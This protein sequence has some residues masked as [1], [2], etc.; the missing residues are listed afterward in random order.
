MPRI[1]DRQVHCPSLCALLEG[2]EK[3]G[4]DSGRAGGGRWETRHSPPVRRGTHGGQ[5][6]DEPPSR[7]PAGPRPAR[8][9]RLSAPRPASP[10]PERRP[11]AARHFCGPPLAFLNRR[12]VLCRRRQP[13]EAPRH[14]GWRRRHAAGRPPNT[15]GRPRSPGWPAAAAAGGG[16]SG[17]GVKEGRQRRPPNARPYLAAVRKAAAAQPAPLFKH[18]PQAARTWAAAAAAAPPPLPSA[19]PGGG[20]GRVV[21]SASRPAPPQSGRFLPSHG[22]QGGGGRC[23]GSWVASRPHARP[24][25]GGCGGDRL[26][27]GALPAALAGGAEQVGAPPC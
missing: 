21:P 1:S 6:E 11:G 3:H 26:R 17:A 18:L 10:R 2:S 8:G 5:P 24:A 20:L 13:G 16:Q 9:A 12:R 25:S 27:A 14:G 4:S 7:N 19:P 15:T 22:S 23:G